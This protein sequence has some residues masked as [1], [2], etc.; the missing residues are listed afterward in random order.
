MFTHKQIKKLEENLNNCLSRLL[1]FSTPN[2]ELLYLTGKSR[3]MQFK[4]ESEERLR[5]QSS[6]TLENLHA[7]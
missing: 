5:V 7:Q 6:E 2:E 4:V 1:L 3:L